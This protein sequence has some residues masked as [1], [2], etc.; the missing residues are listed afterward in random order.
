MQY[1]FCKD[2]VQK[3]SIF[4]HFFSSDKADKPSDKAPND[5]RKGIKGKFA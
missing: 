1:R 5:D 3:K 4:P 2:C